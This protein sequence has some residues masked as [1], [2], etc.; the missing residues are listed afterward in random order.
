MNQTN[1][2]YVVISSSQ[3]LC[4][5]RNRQTHV[6]FDFAMCSRVPHSVIS[7]T[8]VGKSLSCQLESYVSNT[9]V[10]SESTINKFKQILHNFL[11]YCIFTQ[12]N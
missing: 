7:V 9:F 6:Y 4:V 2:K 12:N 8:V 5:T 11:N 10:I 1:P 3:F